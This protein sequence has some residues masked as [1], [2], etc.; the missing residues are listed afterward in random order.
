MKGKGLY[1]ERESESPYLS[2]F[3]KDNMLASRTYSI[4]ALFICF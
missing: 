3:K 1:G 4:I 2:L